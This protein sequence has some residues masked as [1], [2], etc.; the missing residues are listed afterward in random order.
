MFLGLLRPAF[1]LWGLYRAVTTSTSAGLWILAGALYLVTMFGV[2]LGYHRYWPHR[3]FEARFPLQ[4][5]L[6]VASGMPMEGDI[7]QWV[8]NHRPHHRFADVV[9][10]DPHSPYEYSGWHG[11][12]GLAWAQGIWLFFSY[13]RP[14]GYATHR[15]LAGN[16]LVQW[17]RRAFPV[18]VVVNFLVPLAFCPLCGWNAVLIA[19][20]LRTAALMTATGFAVVAG[21]EG[22][23]S[24][25]HADPLRPAARP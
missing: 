11:Y 9:G 6:A 16:R 17:Q 23:H 18:L 20:A 10:K 24:W 1:S 22:N 25:H 15:D 4:V 5:V 7:Q 3:G 19:G 13:E 12:K 8:L 2:M 14:P 21:G